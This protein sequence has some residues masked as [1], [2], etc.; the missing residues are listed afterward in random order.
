MHVVSGEDAERLSARH[1]LARRRTKDEQQLAYE[2]VQSAR[3]AA[4]VAR[5]TMGVF[6]VALHDGE[7]WRGRTGAQ[8]FRRFLQ[9]DG[10]EPPAAYQYMKVARAFVLEH[11][12]APGRIAL[13]G[14]RALVDAAQYLRHYD[15]ENGVESNVDEVVGIVTTLPPAEAR[16]ELKERFASRLM[17]KPQ[18]P[19]RSTPVARILN[20]VDLLTHEERAE[21]YAALRAGPEQR[22]HPTPTAA[23]V[24]FEITED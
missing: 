15:P 22:P 11:A 24:I 19:G 13:A 6:L 8:S 12:V 7:G 18:K 5:I 21:L 10:I 17:D 3:R 2:G 1:H 23:K 4:G 9:E 20:H 14:M 16:C